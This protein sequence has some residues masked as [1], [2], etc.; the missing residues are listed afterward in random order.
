MQSQDEVSRFS[1]EPTAK[2][3][4]F[5]FSTNKFS[6]FSGGF[7]NGKTTAG[8]LKAILLSQFPKN[9]GLIGRLTYPE[10]RDTTQRTFFELCPPEY[11]AKENGGEWRK[12]DNLVR[13]ANGSEIM[14]RHMDTIS[15]KELLSLNIGW[16]FIDQAEEIGEKVFLILMSRLRLAHIPRRFGFLAC[17]PA[18]G[19]WIYNRFVLPTEDGSISKNYFYV[20]ATTKENPHLPADYIPTLLES[21]PDELI[22]RYMEGK[23]EVYEGQI[24]PE[25]NRKTHVI[26]PFMVPKSWEHIVAIDHGMVNPTCALWAAIDYDGN[27]YIYD[28]YYQP[29]IVSQHAKAIL[30]KS[31][32]IEVSLWLIDPSTGTKSREKD[33]MPWS[34]TEEY[35][36]HGIYAI[37]AN[38]QKLAG[39]NRVKEFLKVNP[40]KRN[41]RNEDMGSPRLFIFSNCKNLQW[42]ITQYQW[43]Q[44]RSLSVRNAPEQPRD[45]NDHAM[46][47]LRYMIMSRFPP[48]ARRDSRPGVPMVAPGR[49][50]NN[51]IITRPTHDSGENLFGGGEVD[52]WTQR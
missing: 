38:D 50:R 48:P 20:T 49:T 44:L 4:E 26:K 27:V 19:N 25:F 47:A 9:F 21:Y 35:E 37:P 17:N 36:D 30:E 14:F 40:K 41:P 45:F 39:I 29:G 42:E 13:F 34:V 32:N 3:S 24:Y 5:I 31:R 22:K 46:D 51:N 1:I 23:W 7:G 12:S 6:C 15:E 8:C 28:E 11:Y 43:K 10:L 33:G 16:F 18:P 52:E 2:Q